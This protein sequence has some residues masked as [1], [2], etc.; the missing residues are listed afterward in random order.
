[1]VGEG[2]RCVDR[3]SERAV[4]G[5]TE[6]SEESQGPWECMRDR[7]LCLR[8][9]VG[10]TEHLHHLIYD[11]IRTRSRWY[12]RP[13]PAHVH[14]RYRN[15]GVEPSGMSVRT[16]APAISFS[17]LCLTHLIVYCSLHTEF[18][19]CGYINVY[20]HRCIYICILL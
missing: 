10:W 9:D 3:G 7:G 11:P 5:W 19:M 12:G 17:H 8:S 4:R 14:Q 18:L 6:Y 13:L 15:E 1:M 20:M 16:Y 2:E